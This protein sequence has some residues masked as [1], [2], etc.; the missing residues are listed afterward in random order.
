MQK[1]E[2]TILDFPSYSWRGTWSKRSILKLLFMGTCGRATYL[3]GLHGYG[4]EGIEGY[5]DDNLRIWWNV[6]KMGNT[7][8]DLQQD[9]DVCGVIPLGI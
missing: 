7:N 5:D 6:L 9:A 2:G 8:S 3:S 4:N 1:S